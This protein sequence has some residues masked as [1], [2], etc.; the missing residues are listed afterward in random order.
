MTVALD[1]EI[2]SDLGKEHFPI[3]TKSLSECG[4]LPL[5]GI[6]GHI[7]TSPAGHWGPHPVYPR[8]QQKFRLFYAPNGS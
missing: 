8:N 6:P 3:P 4:F 2:R 5:G 1:S 7:P